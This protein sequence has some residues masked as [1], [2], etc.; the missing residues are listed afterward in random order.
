VPPRSSTAA[1]LRGGDRPGVEPGTGAAPARAP[2]A[3]TSLAHQTDRDFVARDLGRSVRVVAPPETDCRP[4]LWR[5]P[6]GVSG[7]PAR[8]AG[9]R[10][11]LHASS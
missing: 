1:R 4:A 11:I 9:R 10:N 6:T 2:P 3:G 5:A 8:T 7:L